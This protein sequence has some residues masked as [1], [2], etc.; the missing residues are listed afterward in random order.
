MAEKE[1]YLDCEI[2]GVPVKRKN[3]PSHMENVHDMEL[4]DDALEISEEKI[5]QRIR[6][7]M[8]KAG[9]VGVAA[10]LIIFTVYIGLQGGWQEEG[11]GN[12]KE[13]TIITLGE[14][15]NV[16]KTEDG[17]S[18][19]GNHRSG[20]M[21]RPCVLFLHGMNEDRKAWSGLELEISDKGLATLSVD[22]RGHGESIY[23]NG[24]KKTV[25][26]FSEADFSYMIRDV[27]GWTDAVKNT[28]YPGVIIVGASIG[29]N[30]A[31]VESD[32]NW[33]VK[34]LA[35]LSPGKDYHGITTTGPVDNYGNRPILL[36]AAYGDYAYQ[37]TKN[38]E[39]GL[40]QHQVTS[41]YFD[42]DEHG[43]NLLRY[44][45]LSKGIINWVL[46]V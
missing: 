27:H 44:E 20:N 12:E 29:A 36:S 32:S 7:K 2:C 33:F 43:T 26:S 22:L 41:Y 19:V 6:T 14:G 37:P 5:R 10:I 30:L 28:G 8:K 35:L 13:T 3:M 23:H 31:L 38:I 25:S 9:V 16:I 42:G 4:T 46:N 39:D 18:I 45:E 17:W 11:G 15:K 1:D 21:S 34:A 40:S 24:E